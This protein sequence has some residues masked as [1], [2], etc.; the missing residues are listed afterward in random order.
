MNVLKAFNQDGWRSRTVFGFDPV[1]VTEI[2]ITRF[3]ATNPKKNV[4]IDAQRESARDWRLKRPSSLIADAQACQN[5]AQQLSVMRVQNFISQRW[6]ATV[7]KATGLPDQPFMQVT[8]AAGPAALTLDVGN[9]I[10][11]AYSAVLHERGEAVCFTLPKE[12]IEPL[13]ALTADSLRPRRLFPRIENSLVGLKK[14]SP[15]GKT[16][17]WSFGRQSDS[18]RGKWEIREPFQALAHEGK[19]SGCF[20]QVVVDLDRVEVAEFLDPATPFTPE[21]LLDLAVRNDQV[22]PHYKLEV[23][24]AGERTLVRV[25]E[26]ARPDE[27]FA[28]SGKLQEVLGLDPELF[29]DRAVFPGDKAFA[30]RVVH[31]KLATPKG[32]VAELEKGDSKPSPVAVGAT[33]EALISKLTSAA[34][35]LFGAPCK[36]YVRQKDVPGEPFAKE[37][38]RLTLTTKEGE[39][40]LIV[41]SA[42]D[43]GFYCRLTPRQPD[44]VL[45]VIPR[46][47]LQE[48]FALIP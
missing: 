8:V 11:G 43:D 25:T 2:A 14:S 42:G 15:D 47:K 19:G 26:P 32:V 13:I 39:E 48:L 24:R 29:R 40:T 41:G 34:N 18:T 28:V 23:A 9:F 44:D 36:G 30:A 5:L 12:A 4:Y 33:P 6:S 35:G 10:N 1:G 46:E 7:V 20:A 27:L 22:V 3:D 37:I 31:W 38:L 17:A 21:A 45:M 16:T